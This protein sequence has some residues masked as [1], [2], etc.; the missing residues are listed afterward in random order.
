[1]AEEKEKVK[2]KFGQK[3][4]DLDKYI[5]NLGTNLQRYLDTKTDWSDGQ[6]QE[7]TNAYNR[8]INGLIE[9]RDTNSG[10]FYSDDAG[11]IY[12][13]T[14]AF[15]DIDDDMNGADDMNYF[16]DKKGN[17]ITEQAYD[18]L[19]NRKRKK[20]SAF[21]ANREVANYFN[22]VGRY[23]SPYEA[24]KK[25]KFDLATHGFL[26]WWKNEN[27]KTGG[28]TDLRPYI[29]KDAPVD[30]KRARTNRLSYLSGQIDDYLKTINED[31]YDW[32][33]S[34][35]KS[36]ENYKNALNAFKTQMQD[37]T[38][39]NDDM[40]A[41]NQAGIDSNFYND[42]F[43]EEENPTITDTERTQ[44]DAQKTQEERDALWN[45]EKKRRWELYVANRGTYHKDSPYRVTLGD[46]NGDDGLFSTTKW[47]E[48]FKTDH[49]HYNEMK[50]GNYENYLKKFYEN[51]FTNESGRALSFIINDSRLSRQL[52]DG[53]YYIPYYNDNGTSK[54]IET[55]TALIYDPSSGTLKREFIGEVGDVWQGIKDDFNISQGWSN[56]YDKYEHGGVITYLQFGG[57]VN[58][59]NIVK[60]KLSSEN[61]IAAQRAGKSEAEYNAD[62]RKIGTIFTDAEETVI[63]PDTSF[64]DIE[65]ARIGGAIADIASIGLAFAPGAGTVGSAAAGVSSTAM[66]AWADFKDEGVSTGQ[67]FKNMFINLGMDIVGLIPGGGAA[68]KGAKILKSLVK[69]LPKAALA[70]G[71]VNG[72]KNSDQ[73]LASID[74]AIKTPGELN[75]GDWQNIAQGLS[76]IAGGSQ[77]AGAAVKNKANAKKAGVA[78]NIDKKVAV[79]VVDNAG[80]RK[81]VLFEGDDAV[82]IKKARDN[83]NV[84]EINEILHSYE[85]TKDF[86]VQQA[87]KMGL[88]RGNKWYKWQRVDTGKGAVAVHDLKADAHGAYLDR[89]KF[90]ADTYESDFDMSLK[91]D[92]TIEAIAKANLESQKG[93]ADQLSPDFKRIDDNKAKKVSKLEK[94]REQAAAKKAEIGTDTWARA[95]SEI[96]QL[97]ARKNNPTY[98]QRKADLDNYKITAEANKRELWRVENDIALLEANPPAKMG[99]AHPD[100]GKYI[101]SDAEVRYTQELET[102]RAKRDELTRKVNED[103]VHINRETTWLDVDQRINDLQSRQ[104]ELTTRDAELAN[105]EADIKKTETSVGRYKGK[106][107]KSY[108]EFIKNHQDLDG[109][110]FWDLPGGKKS[111]PVTVEE[112]QNILRSHGI[113]FNKK[114]GNIPYLRKF[115]IGGVTHTRTDKKDK[116]TDKDG[117]MTMPSMSNLDPTLTFGLGRAIYSDLVNRDNTDRA[118]AA[119]KPVVK[120]AFQ[121]TAQPVVSS[122]NAEIQGQQNASNL[123][124]LSSKS[125]TSD[126]NLHQA[127]QLDA[128]SKAQGFINQGNM[129]S[130]EALKKSMELNHQIENEN[131]LARHNTAMENNMSFAETAKNKNAH[132]MAYQATKHNIYDTFLQQMEYETR[133]KLSK[134]EALSDS[135]TQQDISDMLDYDLG[136]VATQNGM[137][138]SDASLA[139]WKKV[140]SGEVQYTDLTDDEKQ[141]FLE[142]ENA[143][144]QLSSLLLRKAKG[145]GVSP[146]FRLRNW[147][148]NNGAPVEDVRPEWLEIEKKGGTLKENMKSEK[149]DADRLH[150]Q[151]KE[152]ADRHQKMLNKLADSIYKL[153]RS[154]K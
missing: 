29:D 20:Y 79:D 57:G 98:A 101:P 100:T 68:T 27:N 136:A 99:T 74:K 24:K 111:K 6:R 90:K 22:Q 62:K 141:A 55:N 39:N 139:A 4:I 95:K 76:L 14:G 151:L 52:S 61:K 124:R 116:K 83:N 72:L 58:V 145:I 35:F 18:K 130:D 12:D 30:G 121:R 84:A 70:I 122:N 148:N 48:S 13:S 65:Y 126:A 25:E 49:P 89:G 47:A 105:L 133:Q 77:V 110:I 96:D 109:N 56:P 10:R 34:S 132:E 91:A 51:P 3:E 37:A 8:Y 26:G 19:R 154:N 31:S 50:Q 75:V 123:Y 149:A 92:D 86:N 118:I 107:P 78:N 106:V 46:Y 2:Y 113:N 129:L 104:T 1:M 38:W 45:A 59:N 73:I 93:I 135:L 5:Y 108:T 131:A 103:N 41:A 21:S 53:R 17:Q 7:F 42:F 67:A 146:F 153:K 16:Y 112:F 80:N 36:F 117:G 147:S 140:R 120:T 54:D 143:S 150:K 144:K 32:E 63:N 23:M 28:K 152:A 33:G 85:S 82:R 64:T 81:S 87:P 102:L 15:S 137:T 142:A 9:Q 119:E 97:T 11:N 88:Q 94:L 43:T 66:N 128:A 134:N 127:V 125:L 114:G 60:E 69:I 71:A 44:N 138:L 40:I 115:E